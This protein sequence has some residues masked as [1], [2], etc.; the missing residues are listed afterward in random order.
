MP[1]FPSPTCRC[2][3]A[4]ET[5]RHI[6]AECPRFS[7]ARRS[8]VDPG[9]GRMDVRSLVSKADRVQLLA[10]WFIRLRILPQ[11]NLAEELLYGGEE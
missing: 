9:T 5:A 2:G 7:E 4:Y 3:R 10:R 6:I 11:F 1:E 8:L